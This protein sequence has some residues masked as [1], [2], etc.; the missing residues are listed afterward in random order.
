MLP[1]YVWLLPL[2]ASILLYSNDYFNDIKFNFL[3]KWLNIIKSVYSSL[4]KSNI[5]LNK[6][7]NQKVFTSTELKKYTNLKDGL[8]ISILGQIFDVT[9]GAKHYGPGATYHV[10][11]GIIFYKITCVNVFTNLTHIYMYMYLCICRS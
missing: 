4:K 8:Y 1:K 6:D 3:D 7:T 9:K 11:T 10:F 2:F 5:K